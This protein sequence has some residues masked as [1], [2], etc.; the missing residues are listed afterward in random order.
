VVSKEFRLVSE[1]VLKL[2]LRL[3]GAVAQTDQSKIAMNKQEC[4]CVE[5]VSGKYG[6][7]PSI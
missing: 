5:E 4:H 2:L 1:A 3:I 7:F 6:F